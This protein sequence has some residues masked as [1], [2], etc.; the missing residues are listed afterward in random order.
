MQDNAVPLQQYPGYYLCVPGSGSPSLLATAPTERPNQEFRAEI[1]IA[2]SEEQ[3]GSP[4]S[5]DV[6]SVSGVQPMKV[7][8]PLLFTGM[9]RRV[10]LLPQVPVLFPIPCQG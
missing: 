8:S 5:G 7:F 9:V 3:D 10:F 6:L 1:S 4:P 2:D